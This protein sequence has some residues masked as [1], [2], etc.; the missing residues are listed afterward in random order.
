MLLC[1]KRGSGIRADREVAL[2]REQ[3]VLHA[4]YPLVLETG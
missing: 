4:P 3:C 2:T 1:L